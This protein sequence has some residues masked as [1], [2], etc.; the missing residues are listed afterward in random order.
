MAEVASCRRERR[1]SMPE[2]EPSDDDQAYPNEV[3]RAMRC[4]LRAEKLIVKSVDR[5]SCSS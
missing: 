2:R 3:M 5:V 1:S 4:E